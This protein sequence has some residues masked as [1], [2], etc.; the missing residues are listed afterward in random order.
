MSTLMPPEVADAVRRL[1]MECASWPEHV[2]ADWRKVRGFVRAR[3]KE[4]Q[5]AMPAISLAAQE[6]VQVRNHAQA[7]LDAM[8]GVFGQQHDADAEDT[9][10]HAKLPVSDED[11]KR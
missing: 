11:P 7:A 4:S 2:Q 10:R 8:T 9:A 3:H 5:R 6:V 1:D